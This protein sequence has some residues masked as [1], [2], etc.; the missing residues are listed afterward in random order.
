MCQ[1]QS[2]EDDTRAIVHNNMHK[3]VSIT[4]V[5]FRE[6]RVS[7]GYS[8]ESVFTLRIKQILLK[9]SVLKERLALVNNISLRDHN[10]RKGQSSRHFNN[11]L[12]KQS[13]EKRMSVEYNNN[14]CISVQKKNS[15]LF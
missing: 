14:S 8:I 11:E 3:K 1:T 2:C 13:R 7:Y 12:E 15:F 10:W 6:N 5:I 9:P 4:A